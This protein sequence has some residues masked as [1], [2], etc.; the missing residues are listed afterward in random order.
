MSFKELNAQIVFLE[1]QA[2][3]CTDEDHCRDIKEAIS[4][5]Y[6]KIKLIIAS[7]EAEVTLKTENPGLNQNFR[8]IERT[9]ASLPIFYGTDTLEAEGFINKMEQLYTL[10]VKEIDPGLEQ[11]FVMLA[12]LKFGSN[13]FN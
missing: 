8:I 10:L 9:L 5:I 6:A 11:D 13:V 1:K 2:T 4:Q 3:S 7:T 12:K